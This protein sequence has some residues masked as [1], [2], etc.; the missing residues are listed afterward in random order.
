MFRLETFRLIGKT[1]RR[2]LSLT[3]IV[4]I[5]AGFMMGLLSTPDVM[6]RSV[7][8]YYDHNK[9]PDVKIYSPY[10]FG[11]E[12][13][14]TLQ[15]ANGIDSVFASKEIDVYCGKNGDTSKVCRISEI[16]RK[17]NDY[18]LVEGRLPQR[19]GECI[20]LY[21]ETMETMDVGDVVTLDYGKKNIDEYLASDRYTVVGIFK[22]PEFMSKF[23]GTSTFNNEELQFVIYVPNSDFLTDY[24]T[25]M[26]LQLEDAD[27]YM[28]NTKAY[29]RYINKKITDVEDVASEQQSYRRDKI[30]K[31]AEETLDQNEKLFNQMKEEGQRQLDDA[32]KQLQEAN[33]QIVTYEAQLNVLE[34]VISSLQA[35]IEKDSDILGS[36]YSTTVDVEGDINNILE[37]A[38]LDGIYFGS[39]T[40]EYVYNE[41][42]KTVAQYNSLRGQLNSAKAQ[43]QEGLEEYTEAVITFEKEVE[44]AELQLK[45]A[46]QEL[47][48]LPSSEWIILDRD[49]FYSAVMYKNNT[50]QMASIGIYMPI[51]FFLVAALVCLTTMKRLVDEQRGQIGIY[52][53][54]GYSNIQIIGKYVTYAMLAS[55]VGGIAGIFVGQAL[56]PTV[57]YD[58][59]RML[60]NLP[61]MRVMFP[62][63]YAV[64]S[65]GS[66]VILMCGLTAYVVNNTVK[67]VPASL[68]RPVAPK[69]VK[70]LMIEKIRFLWNALSFTSKI[71]ARNIFRY[72]ARFL[73]TIAGIAGCTGL[74]ILGFGI[75]DSVSD[76][77][78]IQY[79]KILTYTDR[80][81]LES[82]E[83]IDNFMATLSRDPNISSL[84]RHMT[85]MTKVYLEDD[86]DTANMVVISPYEASVAF[87]L[88]ETDRKTPIKLDNSGVVVSEKF[89]KN[90]SLKVGD[91]ITVES[92]NGLK[93]TVTIN[94][95]CEMYYQHFVFMTDTLYEN[96]FGEKA[97]DNVIAVKTS[98]SDLLKVEASNLE[99]CVSVFNVGTFRE[100][101]FTMVSALNLIIL[102]IILVAGSLAFVVLVNLTQVNISERVREIAT[103]K[104]LGF[105]DHEINMYIFKEILLLSLIGCVV[106]VPIGII[107][108]HFIMNS[109]NME[110]FMFSKVINL[111]SYIISFII[112]ILFTIIVLM[113]MRKPL[114][115]VDM[116]ESLKSVE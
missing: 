107:E 16:S 25:T 75:R 5:G 10:G 90:H 67:D 54:L 72:K 68:M 47:D 100:T 79:G 61:E 84:S 109:L 33:I 110:G 17:N 7:D 8:I 42:N 3:V 114:Q 102:V 31:E 26:Y 78:D 87:G 95:I 14:M 41:Y 37:I 97:K 96:A 18:E 85:Y 39:G 88:N 13:Y 62:V 50:K 111:P 27:K 66:F 76:V 94:N 113:F 36:I 11:V 55:L 48:E 105:N 63:K 99:G 46:R 77:V 81:Y 24:Y 52:V 49:K 4:F 45:L 70:E 74:L 82:D 1:F 93:A 57:I 44:D 6:R 40:M 115:K 91:R 43:Y 108:H 22:S 64:I 60:Y 29:D 15:K 51:M 58:T 28:S 30:I 69:K 83:Y 2:F 112:T 12:D 56:F 104:V 92:V 71:T 98:N 86:D 35:S 65:V 9:L 89:A 80:I 32:K 53:A 73:M 103:L 19:K 21:D 20:V 38:G 116:V 34:G 23:L 101:F 106:G 59:W